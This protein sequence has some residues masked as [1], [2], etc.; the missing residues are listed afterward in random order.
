MLNISFVLE[1]RYA[2]QSR[3]SCN[4]PSGTTSNFRL[5]KEWKQHLET[6]KESLQ[7]L[8]L[9][10][11]EDMGNA[12]ETLASARSAILAAEASWAELTGGLAGLE[13]VKGAVKGLVM[14]VDAYKLDLRTLAKGEVDERWVRVP[15]NRFRE[16]VVPAW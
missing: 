11:L 1:R 2:E 13:D 15:G 3:R 12:T 10:G 9:S 8:N 16:G 5:I 6:E 7:K 14:I 4:S